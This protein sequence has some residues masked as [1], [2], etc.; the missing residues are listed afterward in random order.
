MALPRGIQGQTANPI[1][2][3]NSSKKK[4]KGR[5]KKKRE[6]QAKRG[7][8]ASKGVAKRESRAK[9]Q[10]AKKQKP[11]IPQVYM[12]VPKSNFFFLP[13][14]SHF[15]IPFQIPM[16]SKT[17]NKKHLPSRRSLFFCSLHVSRDL[18][19]SSL[20]FRS[21]NSRSYCARQPL[22]CL[23]GG[24]SETFPSR[25]DLHSIPAEDALDVSGAESSGCLSRETMWRPRTTARAEGCCVC[26]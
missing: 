26:E 14:R 20:G 3:K 16:S 6:I 1:V 2:I 25:L 17:P 15:V 8:S 13:A 22:S 24:R 5:E 4:V 11:Q 18:G 12:Q 10:K 23:A 19:L 7:T 9:K 21:P